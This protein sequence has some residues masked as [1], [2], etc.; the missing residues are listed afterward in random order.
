MSQALFA[1]SA[2][3]L[4]GEDMRRSS[5]LERQIPLL[6]SGH[7]GVGQEFLEQ[8]TVVSL[9]LHGCRYPSRHECPVGSWV[10]LQLT[11]NPLGEN[12]RSV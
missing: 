5:R 9:N 3:R 1:G 8:T 11:G 4:D 12:A 2:T 6:I 7:D 10:T